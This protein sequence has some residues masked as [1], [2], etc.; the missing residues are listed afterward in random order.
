MKL[1]DDK[2]Q[3]KI[4]LFIMVDRARALQHFGSEEVMDS[5]LGRFPATIRATVAQLE[6]AHYVGKYDDMVCLL[7]QLRGAASWVCA[8]ALSKATYDMIKTVTAAVRDP[9]CCTNALRHLTEEVESTCEAIERGSES[10]PVPVPPGSMAS[11]S[12]DVS[13]VD[14]SSLDDV[15]Q[16]LDAWE[17]ESSLFHSM[18]KRFP[19]HFDRTLKQM[20][21]GVTGGH[22]LD[23]KRRAHSLKCGAA[24]MGAMPL[25]GAA[26]ALEMALNGALETGGGGSH[27]NIQ[28]HGHI[29][30]LLVVITVHSSCRHTQASAVLSCCSPAS[31]CPS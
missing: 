26:A 6:Q 29:Q 28:D 19:V 2:N 20:R 8:D 14:K 21:A 4:R 22:W 5:C 24:M 15:L 17:N 11:S 16:L 10:A 23:L 9:D 27:D 18:A 25:S 1:G 31:P 13:S 30:A 12:A 7:Y 3:T